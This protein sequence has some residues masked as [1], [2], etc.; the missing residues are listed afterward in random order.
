MHSNSKL[1][2][3]IKQ[4]IGF[5]T[6]F[7]FVNVHMYCNLVKHRMLI[8]FHSFQVEFGFPQVIS[9]ISYW[10]DI[11]NIYIKVKRLVKPK[12]K[13]S[14]VWLCA[15]SQIVLQMVTIQRW[16]IQLNVVRVTASG[17]V[18]STCS[19]GHNQIIFMC[20]FCVYSLAIY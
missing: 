1:R 9:N 5:N 14:D 3:T 6:D 17:Y 18:L 8:G 15:Y 13:S 12:I 11:A 7:T 20:L 10:I 19:F 16:K 4:V 2:A